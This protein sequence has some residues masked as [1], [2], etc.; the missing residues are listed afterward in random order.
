MNWAR[1]IIADKSAVLLTGLLVALCPLLVRHSVYLTPDIIA[2]FFVAAALMSSSMILKTR[3]VS[4]Y[5][6][7][8]IFA[9][10]AA[11]VK[12]NA[13]AVAIALLVAHVLVCGVRNPEALSTGHRRVVCHCCV[14]ADL[15]IFTVGF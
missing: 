6:T 3:A 4:W 11:S 14:A 9:G 2:A 5:I 10:L 15:A 12:Y 7:A 1:E 8:G 13:G